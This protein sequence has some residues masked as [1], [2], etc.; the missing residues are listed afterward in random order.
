MEEASE[1]A[2]AGPTPSDASCGAPVSSSLP[3]QRQRP[4]L[5]RD[6]RVIRVAVQVGFAAAILLLLLFLAT[7]LISALGRLGILP[8]LRFVGELAGFDIGD[9]PIPF[10][11]TRS[12]GRAILVGLLNTLRVSAVG[13]I[14]CTVLGVGVGLARLSTNYLVSRL[15]TAYVEAFRN[16]PLLVLLVFLKIGI[17]DNLPLVR[18]ALILPGP[19]FISNRGVALPWYEPAAAWP[20]FL[21]ALAVALG[22]GVA[23]ALWLGRRRRHTGRPQLT[24]LWSPL[25]TVVLAGLALLVLRPA[26]VTLPALGRFNVE[27]GLTLT[28]EF[29]AVWLALAVFT[30]A[31][32]AEAV[33]AGIQAVP[34]GQVE[35]ARAVGLTGFQS[36]Q[37]VIFP[38]G[39]RV[40]IPPVINQYLNLIKNSSLAAAVGYPELYNISGTIYNQTGRSLEMIAIMMVLYLSLSLITSAL[41]NWYN[42]R[43]QLVER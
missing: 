28:P 29:L 3:S 17:F 7:N 32:V 5:W 14:L 20:A 21:V 19:I 42:A 39:L 30:S 25:T 2:P 23:V 27:G 12:F 8:S 38:Q 10:D 4:P 13:I 31:F 16:I 33:R 11:R 26:S 37:L 15:A 24:T 9:S 43:V 6:E 1:G 35:A 22:A 34:K 41:L 40:M 18:E 36:M